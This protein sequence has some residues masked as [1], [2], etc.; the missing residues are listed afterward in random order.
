MEK[1]IFCFLTVT[2]FALVFGADQRCDN[3][4]RPDDECDTDETR[5]G[6]IFH[7]SSS[8][9]RCY[10]GEYCES[11]DRSKYF[12]THEECKKSCNAQDSEEVGSGGGIEDRDME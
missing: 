12:S 9:R 4:Y 5:L 7:F 1:M 8:T 11:T 10:A 3:I 2:L 6:E